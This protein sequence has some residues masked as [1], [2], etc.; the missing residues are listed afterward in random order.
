MAGRSGY[1][2]EVVEKTGNHNPCERP[3]SRG[4][5]SQPCAPSPTGGILPGIRACSSNW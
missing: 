2:R 1:H 5:Y 3:L 4:A